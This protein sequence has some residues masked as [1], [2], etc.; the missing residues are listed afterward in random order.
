MEN[1]KN[2]NRPLIGSVFL[3]LSLHGFAQTDSLISRVKISSNLLISYNS[4]LI[5]PGV[6]IGIEIPFYSV[7]LT[8]NST[9]GRKKSIIKDRFISVNSGWYHHPGFH[10]NLY[11]TVEWT[12]RRNYKNRLFNDFS[13]GTG[14]SRTF[15]GGT[16]YQADKNG[17]VKIIKSAGYN[18]ALIIAGAGIG[19]DFSK[20]RGIPLSVFSKFD[21]LTMFPY[22][23][24][25]YFRPLVELGLI[26]KPENFL[27][28]LTKRIVKKK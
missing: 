28:I 19:F 26:Y 13:F 1:R 12:M 22:N 4:S 11:F 3:L 10:D 7:N 20:K 5:Y 9:A 25:I 2:F 8:K 15:L 23:S 18:Y 16:T 14:Y 21:V 27:Q 17:T 6:R 24:T